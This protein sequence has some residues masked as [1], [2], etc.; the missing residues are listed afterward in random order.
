MRIVLLPY[1]RKFSIRRTL[2][3]WLVPTF[4]IVAMLTAGLSYRMFTHMVADF[5][6][7]QMLQLGNSV[8]QHGQPIVPPNASTDRVLERGIYVIQIFDPDGQLAAASW[9]G[10]SGISMLQPGFHNIQEH[11]RHWRVYATVGTG[12][13]TVQVLQSGSFRSHLAF[14]RAG[15]AALPVLVMLPVSMLVLLGVA[16][17][18]SLALREVGGM[19]ARQKAQSIAELPIDRVPDEIRPLVSSFNGLLTRLRDT[20]S[21]QRR[22]VQDAAHE[23]RTPIAAMRLQLD[24]LRDELGNH[25][26]VRQL[27]HLELGMRRAQRLVDQLLKMSHQEAAAT[28]ASTSV[29][30]HA[31]LRD[32]IH[33]L[34]PLADLRQ[35]DLGLTASELA[36]PITLQ[37]APGDLR[38]AIDNLI[39]N[40]L[41]YTPEGGIVDVRL[42]TAQGR[43]VVEVVDTGPGIPREFISRVFDRFFRVPGSPVAGSG[44]G[45]AIA[46]SAAQ[47]CSLRLILSNRFDRSGLV[48]RLEAAP[49]SSPP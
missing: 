15:A 28:E 29:D 31:Q 49:D 6:D 40:A 39:D 9:D 21:A 25:S 35:I 27:E 4:L 43:A 45:L 47:R 11:G 24:N 17:V 5:L 22:F 30:L 10:V 38:S 18:I 36:A 14:Q 44:L 42:S 1:G 46:Q 26:A 33:A 19:A 13:Q 41:R 12:G 32:S 23:L 8:A 16:R 2:L 34:M 3:L 7:D 48:A 20:F 37:C